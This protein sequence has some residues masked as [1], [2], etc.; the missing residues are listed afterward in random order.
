MFILEVHESIQAY[1]PR[2]FLGYMSK[3]G[4]DNSWFFV[5]NS[6]ASTRDVASCGIF[7]ILYLEIKN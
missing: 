7:N 6:L 4:I 1:T 5:N 3:C 2:M